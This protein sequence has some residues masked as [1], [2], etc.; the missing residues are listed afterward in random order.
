MAHKKR[1]GPEGALDK[2]MGGVGEAVGRVSGTGGKDLRVA[3][4]RL[5]SRIAPRFRSAPRGAY[6]IGNARE[7][8]AQVARN[9]REDKNEGTMDRAKG[10]M[11]EAG[12]A[13]TGDKSK[14]REGRSDQRKAKAKEKKANLK[15][16]LS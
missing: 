11:K 8:G 12:G 9:S 2:A 14:K 15:D 3:S 5:L 7:K 1:G 6:S 10:R 16:L 4:L 13:L